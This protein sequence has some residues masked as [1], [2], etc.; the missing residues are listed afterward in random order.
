MTEVN[1]ERRKPTLAHAVT[2]N[3][4]IIRCEEFSTWKRL[5]RVT[6]YVLRFINNCRKVN[7]TKQ[8]DPLS[9]K[10][11]AK[12][13]DYWVRRAQLSL[14]KRREKGELSNLTPFGD[15]RGIIKVGGRVN[16]ELISY[17]NQHSTLL[18]YN[19]W[20]AT[21]ITRDVHQ[22]GHPG[23]ATTT[24]KVRKKYWIIKGNKI[25]KRVKRQ[26]TFCKKIE[27]KISNQF[28]ADL[29]S[30][31][32]QPYTPRHLSFIPPVITLGL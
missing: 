10:E 21:L 6:A 27:A 26:C 16:P 4:P 13:E 17:D 23:I 3:E 1:K 20:I 9:A 14:H 32:Q 25:S 31:R 22:Y 24:A 15:E 8:M 19:H 30:C 18:P 5:L 7:N 29:S 28:M 11:I 2:V 12:A